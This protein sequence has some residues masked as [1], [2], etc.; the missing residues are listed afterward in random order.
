MQYAEG[1][2]LRD[3][4]VG[5]PECKSF[6]ATRILED[7]PPVTESDTIEADLHR[8]LPHPALR[9]ALIAVCPF[10]GF[11]DWAIKFPMRPINPQLVEPAQDMQY[12]RKFAMA[13][14]NARNKGVNPLDIAYI[15]LNGLYCAREAGELTDSWLELCVY[16]QSRGLHPD[17]IV[18]ET[19]TDHLTM[20]ELWR[21]IRCFDKALEEYQRAAFDGSVPMELLRHQITITRAGDYSPTILPP[22]MVR[23]VF[24]EAA[25]MAVAVGA[26][27]RSGPPPII[28]RQPDPAALLEPDQEG[29]LHPPPS[30]IR[31]SWANGAAW[32]LDIELAF[33]DDPPGTRRRLTAAPGMDEGPAFEQPEEFEETP[34]YTGLE[35]EPEPE[36]VVYQTQE[37]AQQ[38]HYQ[39]PVVDQPKTDGMNVP[40]VQYKQQEIVRKDNSSVP[41]NRIRQVIAM[42]TGSSSIS[43]VHASAD[44]SSMSIAIS[45]SVLGRVK[46][47]DGKQ[48][49]WE[50][51][52]MDAPTN[53]YFWGAKNPEREDTDP[54]NRAVRRALQ[55][56]KKNP[57]DP[58]DKFPE[59]AI[60]DEDSGHSFTGYQRP[61][62]REHEPEAES[63]FLP[64][65][66]A[67][68]QPAQPQYQ[69]PAQNYQQ[70]QYQQPAQTYQQPQQQYQ[71]P[72]QNYQQPQQQYQQPAQNY[73][74]PQQQY[75]QPAQNYQQP[76]QQ[77]Q[78]PAQNYQQPQQQYQEP[79]QNYQQP[80]QQYQQQ[81]QEP[82]QNY[83]QP[84]QQYQQQYQEP[85]QNYQQ[86]QQNYQQQYQQSAGGAAATEQQATNAPEQKEGEVKEAIQ[87]VESF[88]SLT[89]QPSYQNWIRGYRK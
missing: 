83:Q 8:V 61:V 50:L 59:V 38:A 28:L 43:I 58:T 54:T 17:Q 33:E 45:P 36:P 75:Q 86:P 71:Q 67:P 2:I 88:L 79:A 81:Y 85:A 84:Q 35:P 76:Q 48:S 57:A 24:P 80:Q 27:A 56:N 51:P 9:A 44:G 49:E 69:Q 25:E 13:V 6:F 60:M 40:P 78:Q 26:Q 70:P 63:E 82:A 31:P 39:T 12:S 53:E 1:F 29:K 41:V 68:A 72:T 77:Y 19:G 55:A 14:K 37:Q 62:V 18:V 89:R 16:E 73:Q 30:I 52:P 42:P 66:N 65:R 4:S 46:R 7:L 87:R 10:C 11:A 74:Q 5:C 47:G 3:C 22:W 21:Q 32:D 15:A 64:A 20:A 23:I 34:D